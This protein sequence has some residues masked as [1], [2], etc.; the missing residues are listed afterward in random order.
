MSTLPQP[1]ILA[2]LPS[3]ARYLTLRMRP[4]ASPLEAMQTLAAH[5]VGE[6]QVVG[7]G[8][9]LVRALGA[10]VPGLHDFA[11]PD[12][13]LVKLPSQQGDLWLWLRGDDR[14][15]LLLR[16]R[17]LLRWLQPA[18]ELAEC[19][20]AFVHAGGRDLT[21]YED[22]TENPQGLAAREASVCADGVLAPLGSSLVAVQRW[23]HRLDVFEAMDQAQQD[24]TIGRE[25]LSNE[26]LD[27]AP[28]SAHVKRTAQESFDPEA[29]VLRRSM[30]WTEG[31]EGGLLFTAFGRS[32]DAFEA[33][34]RR[35]SGAED[36]II[37]ALFGISQPQGAA[38]YWCPP[39]HAGQLDWRSALP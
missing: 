36:G 12:D 35:M 6:S 31:M 29:F 33:Q 37:D 15:E 24:A 1:A 38:C 3:Q 11:A 14:G 32:L 5:A 26:E 17:H 30:A 28:L 20:D 25:R 7:L 27:D 9:Q 19:L 13:S 39:I 8:R 22:G 2:P 16:S 4:G 18:F 23:R 10:Q 21:G 34:L